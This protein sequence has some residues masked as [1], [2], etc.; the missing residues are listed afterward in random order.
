MHDI[1]AIRETPELYEKAWAAKGRSGAAAEAIA[2]DAKVR[3][4]QA[5]LQEA[6]ATRNNASKLI[7]QAKAKKDEAEAQRLM[8]EVEAV[9]GVLVE[10][11]EAEKTASE[12]LQDLLAQLPNIPLPDVPAGESEHDNVEVRRWGEPFAIQ[13]PKDHVDLEIGRA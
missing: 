8:G 13:N 12:A 9:K 5:A 4:A 2:L 7:G 6:Q 1:R 11:A 10:Q 3:A